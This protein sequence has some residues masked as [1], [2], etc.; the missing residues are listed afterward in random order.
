MTE[1]T[2]IVAKIMNS[3]MEEM[4]RTKDKIKW[5]KDARVKMR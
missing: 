3:K 4:K 2:K 5:E 1:T